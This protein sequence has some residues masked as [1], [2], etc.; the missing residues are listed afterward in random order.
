M[1]QPPAVQWNTAGGCPSDRWNVNRYGVR[2]RASISTSPIRSWRYAYIKH[3]Q[4]PVY[5][6]YV[7]CAGAFKQT[8]SRPSWLGMLARPARFND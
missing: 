2:L 3:R 7:A 6:Q 5:L 4:L 8:R 1:P